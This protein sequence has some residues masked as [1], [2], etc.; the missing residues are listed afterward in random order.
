VECECLRAARVEA[1]Y[2]RAGIPPVYIGETWRTFLAAYEVSDP[3]VLLEAARA[4]KAARGGH[5]WV[6]V[7]G[8]PTGARDLAAALLLRA[9]CDGG[10]EARR[11]DV[12]S[13]IDVEFAPG[14]GREVYDLPVLALEVGSEP[15]NRWNKVVI[16]KA[17][18][19]RHAERRFTL[20]VTERDPGALASLYKSG[21]IE[22]AVRGR[23]DKVRVGPR[24]GG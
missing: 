15:V 24:A 3:R 22:E 20:L 12:P 11:I 2:R 21:Q 18:R 19:D 6:L 10:L 13:L 23:F 14:R 17:M 8:R 9:A 7:S 4:L 1:R 5:R 16:E